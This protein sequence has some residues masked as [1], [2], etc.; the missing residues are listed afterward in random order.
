MQLSPIALRLAEAAASTRELMRQRTPIPQLPARVELEGT[1]DLERARL[2]AIKQGATI[3]RRNLLGMAAALVRTGRHVYAHTVP[4]ATIARR[5]AANKVARA[6]R[7][8]NRG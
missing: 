4:A 7:K 5:R 3:E 1:D 6:S 8:A 2:E